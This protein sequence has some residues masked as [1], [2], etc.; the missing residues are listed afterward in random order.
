MHGTS[1][2]KRCWMMPLCPFWCIWRECNDIMFM[3]EERLDQ[4][5]KDV[6]IKFFLITI[7]SLGGLICLFGTLLL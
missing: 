6:F 3:V 5:L 1:V 4:S 2:G 7:E